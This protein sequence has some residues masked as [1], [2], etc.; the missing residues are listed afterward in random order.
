[1]SLVYLEIKI[2]SSVPKLCPNQFSKNKFGTL[3]TNRTCDPP[4]RRG[5]LYRLITSLTYYFTNTLIS[6]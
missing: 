1:M 5:M 3:D 2:V 4:L 6:G